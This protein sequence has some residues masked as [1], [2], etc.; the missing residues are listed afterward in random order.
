VLV[1]QKRFLPIATIKKKS[2]RPWSNELHCMR[3]KESERIAMESDD[4]NEKRRNESDSA[5]HIE[6]LSS[7]PPLRGRDV[8]GRR[9]W[10]TC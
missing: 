3:T 6:I 10:C 1:L 5:P 4:E 7:L 2:L 9:E 8:L